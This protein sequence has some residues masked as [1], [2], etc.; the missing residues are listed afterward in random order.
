M[1]DEEDEED[2]E[3]SSRDE[4]GAHAHGKRLP[5]SSYRGKG[6]RGCESQEPPS[7][8]SLQ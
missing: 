3:A 7:P 5:V 8:F 1:D 2:E 4:K 6:A